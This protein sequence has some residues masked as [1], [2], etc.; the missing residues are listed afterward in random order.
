MASLDGL[1][2]E[3]A[4]KRNRPN[5]KVRL[6]TMFGLAHLEFRRL[7]RYFMLE[8]LWH[9]KTWNQSSNASTRKLEKQA[10]SA[11]SREDL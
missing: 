7:D 4:T 11:N 2:F 1:A 10:N 6:I 9:I 3:G 8:C 5:L